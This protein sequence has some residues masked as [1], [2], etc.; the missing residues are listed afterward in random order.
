MRV[1]DLWPNYTTEA[2]SFDLSFNLTSGTGW[3]KRVGDSGSW[4]DAN[5]APS[6]P[7]DGDEPISYRAKAAWNTRTQ[8]LGN[9]GN[10]SLAAVSE[11][12]FAPIAPGDA[13]NGGPVAVDVNVKNLVIKSVTPNEYFLVQE[14]Q[15]A[16]VNFGVEL[17][18][19]DYS[20]P[21]TLTLTIRYTMAA[22]DVTKTI[23]RQATGRNHSILWDLTNSQNEAINTNGGYFTYDLSAEKT[24]DSKQV[25]RSP[26][27]DVVEDQISL[28]TD[29]DDDFVVNY[30]G[31][32]HALFAYKLNE[33]PLPQSV[34]V[35]FY[36]NLFSVGEATGL[37]DQ[38]RWPDAQPA[39][40]AWVNMPDSSS[41]RGIMEARDN[42]IAE[43]RNHAAKPLL[44]FNSGS[45][46]YGKNTAFTFNLTGS[47]NSRF[48]EWQRVNT[49]PVQLGPITIWN[50]T[51][52]DWHHA[53]SWVANSGTENI[54]SD[55]S[56]HCWSANG[57]V[58]ASSERQNTVEEN[59]DTKRCRINLSNDYKTWTNSTTDRPGLTWEDPNG[60]PKVYNDRQGKYRQWRFA[61][62]N[63]NGGD[64]HHPNATFPNIV[65]QTEASVEGGSRRDYRQT[66]RLHEDGSQLGTAGCTGV[67][68]GTMASV[69]TRLQNLKT[70]KLSSDGTPNERRIYIPYMI[71]DRQGCTTNSTWQEGRNFIVWRSSKP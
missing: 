20:Q 45:Q 46:S 18:D 4:S 5:E 56:S 3:Q 28:E 68:S 38:S 14:G 40:D 61:I 37:S 23:V 1:T 43:H 10:H 67:T 21:Y 25:Y 64:V 54:N 55:N 44:N 33:Q 57:P 24:G 63:E 66:I 19:Y 42:R 51:L 35:R 69:W 15:T 39:V 16:P 32:F 36:Q 47:Q 13:Y 31:Q 34:N 26:F 58:P 7:N 70:A 62:Q 22:K 2:K 65:L 48:I 59:E 41:I 8:P 49:N 50:N 11:L 29:S 17:E 30:S 12:S 53:N 6:T 52:T 9:N 60:N 27:I 71:Y